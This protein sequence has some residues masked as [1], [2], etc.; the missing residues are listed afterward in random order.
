MMQFLKSIIF[1][2]SDQR[3]KELETKMA[4]IAKNNADLQEDVQR[5]VLSVADMTEIIK[6]VARTNQT[7]YSD[8]MLLAAAMKDLTE[9]T[10]KGFDDLFSPFKKDDD[11]G[12]LN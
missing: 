3:I 11:D 6:E 10:P 12:Y 4:K 1:R 7:L 9:P 2:R 5:L 8:V